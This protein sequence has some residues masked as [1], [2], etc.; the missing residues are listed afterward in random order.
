MAQTILGRL[1][2]SLDAELTQ[3]ALEAEERLDNLGIPLS[4]PEK[5][6]W[7]LWHSVE[8]NSVGRGARCA[9]ARQ[10]R[11]PLSIASAVF[12][13]FA[14]RR[15]EPNFNVCKGRVAPLLPSTVFRR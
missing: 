2:K 7:E 5:S 6:D 4:N 15:K 9:A 11:R 14:P 3:F 1:I 10:R 12:N 13:G 8:S